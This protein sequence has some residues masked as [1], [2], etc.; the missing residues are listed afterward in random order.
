[1]PY[2]NI[3]AAIICVSVA[4]VLACE[5]TSRQSI[6]EKQA[7]WQSQDL[8][9]Y[10]YLMQRQCFCSPEYTQEMRVTV[11]NNQVIEVVYSDSGESVN[12]K[13]FNQQLTISQWYKLA[14]KSISNENGKT[15]VVFSEY[16][17]YPSRI[18]IDQHIM[19]ADDEYTVII[20][21]LIR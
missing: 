9:R 18:Y 14:L 21:N 2:K 3:L 1:M 4:Q 19:R 20:K 5:E 10:S 13:V 12:D 15:K 6:L 17:S 16:E 11:K 7:H 8:E